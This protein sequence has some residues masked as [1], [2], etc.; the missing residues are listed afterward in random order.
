MKENEELFFM[1]A[2]RQ[3]AGKGQAE[4]FFERLMEGQI[5]QGGRM[6]LTGLVIDDIDNNGQADMLVMV[7]DG[8][9]YFT[10]QDDEYG[11]IYRMKRKP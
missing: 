3:E 11:K 2:E 1:G 8:E 10:N 9:V 6:A 5:F 4:E 7:Q